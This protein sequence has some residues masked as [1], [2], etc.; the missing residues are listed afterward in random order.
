MRSLFHTIMGSGGAVNPKW[1]GIRNYYKFDNNANDSVGTANGTLN[2][3]TS[4]VA[5][6]FDQ[7]I[8]TD[9]INDDVTFAN[10]SFN[11]TGD[12]T[13]AF[14]VNFVSTIV[15]S[16]FMLTNYSGSPSGNGW[17]FYMGGGQITFLF[18][19]NGT[20]NQL[21]SIS[22]SLNTNYRV[23]CTFN[24]STGVHKLYVNG[25]LYAT[26]SSGFS[27]SYNPTTTSVIAQ[28]NN[29]GYCNMKLDE[30]AIIENVWDLATIQDD[31]N[32]PTQYPN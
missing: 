16:P 24:Y 5:G 13:I 15:G 2:G 6:V 7:Q 9:G 23:V 14:N 18:Y 25:V 17:S 3:G 8:L 27:Y 30:L 31:Y 20:F 10:N 26:S 11:L 21:G 12:F 1:N 28:Y 4:Y 22:P 32:T 19:K 29:S